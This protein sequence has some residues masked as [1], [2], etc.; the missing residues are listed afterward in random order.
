VRI[1]LGAPA[2]GV[3]ANRF[4]TTTQTNVRKGVNQQTN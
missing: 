4:N 2:R 1:Y 3:M